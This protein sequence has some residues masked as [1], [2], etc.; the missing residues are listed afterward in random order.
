[1]KNFQ[2]FEHELRNREKCQTQC[3]HAVLRRAFFVL[4][5]FSQLNSNCHNEQIKQLFTTLF[6]NIK[7]LL[8]AATIS[9]CNLRLKTFRRLSQRTLLMFI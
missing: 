5:R 6:D 9:R 1:M 8:I 4:I 2:H 7:T 3:F